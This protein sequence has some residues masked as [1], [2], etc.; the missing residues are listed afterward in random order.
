MDWRTWY[1]GSKSMHWLRPDIWQATNTKYSTS[2]CCALTDIAVEAFGLVNLNFS[3]YFTLRPTASM[4]RF[5]VT[6]L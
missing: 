5:T 4:Q 6:G 2:A 1:I 3:D